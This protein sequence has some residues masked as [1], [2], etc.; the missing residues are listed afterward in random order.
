MQTIDKRQL[1]QPTAISHLG[2]SIPL[3]VMSVLNNIVVIK[4]NCKFK[5]MKKTKKL[6]TESFTKKGSLGSHRKNG[7][8]YVFPA[9]TPPN[10]NRMTNH[11]FNITYE[12][13]HSI[14]PTDNN[15]F[16]QTNQNDGN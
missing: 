1:D 10:F 11:K 7:W 9:Y 15:D 12:I 5:K 14:N 8:C 13:V 3:Y 4:M 16:T 2:Y 6:K